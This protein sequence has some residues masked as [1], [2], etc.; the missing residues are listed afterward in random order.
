[1]VLVVV[2]VFEDVM[3]LYDLTN[4]QMFSSTQLFSCVAHVANLELLNIEHC[5]LIK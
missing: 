4:Q 1:L 5:V 3:H 2:L